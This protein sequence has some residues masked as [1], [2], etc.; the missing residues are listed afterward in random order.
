MADGVMV[1]VVFNLRSEAVERFASDVKQMLGD[2]RKHKGFRSSRLDV[3]CEDPNKLLLLSQWDRLEDYENYVAWRAARGESYDL[4][5]PL[6]TAP[7]R[8]E[9]WIMGSTD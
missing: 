6:S 2:T 7:P 8:R 3:S 5:I 9:I 1:S 4:V